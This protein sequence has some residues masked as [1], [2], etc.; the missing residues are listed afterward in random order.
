MSYKPV[1]NFNK[2][3]TVQ[4]LLYEPPKKQFKYYQLCSFVNPW[5]NKYKIKRFIINEKNEILNIQEG[6]MN[7]KQYDRFVLDHKPNEYKIYNAYD[8][9]YIPMPHMGEIS[10]AQSPLFQDEADYTGFAKF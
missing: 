5:T 8:L 7:Q 4:D 1:Y 9:N 3:A 6:E 2:N 10:V